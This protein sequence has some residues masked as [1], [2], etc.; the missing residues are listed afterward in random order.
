MASRKR[1]EITVETHEILIIRSRK[2]SGRA[3]CIGCGAEGRMI[4]A[5]EA[6]ALAGISMT[7]L[8]EMVNGGDV[9]WVQE[10]TCTPLICLKSLIARLATNPLKPA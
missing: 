2:S 5:D 10:G 4:P 9:H 1:T 7:S 3:R 8:L 6:I